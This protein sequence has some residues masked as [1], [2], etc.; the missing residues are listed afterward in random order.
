MKNAAKPRYKFS[1]LEKLSNQAIIV[2]LVT[3]FVLALIGSIFGTSWEF[4]NDQPI[5]VAHPVWNDIQV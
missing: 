4:A 5:D 1:S 3:Q 2:V